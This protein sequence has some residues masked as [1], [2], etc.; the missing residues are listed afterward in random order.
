MNPLVIEQTRKGSKLGLQRH[1]VLLLANTKL[2]EKGQLEPEMSRYIVLHYNLQG[3]QIGISIS[4]SIQAKHPELPG[5]YL[6]G[7]VMAAVLDHYLKDIEAFCELFSAHFEQLFGK[8]PKVFIEEIE[9]HLATAV[10]ELR[11]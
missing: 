1:K 8:P 4:G 10:L 2:N 7:D 6:T 9:A 11:R 5:N 3:H